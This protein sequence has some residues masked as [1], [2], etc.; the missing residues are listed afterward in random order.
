MGMRDQWVGG[1]EEGGNII[2]Q[3]V[4]NITKLTKSDGLLLIVMERW[5][6]VKGGGGGGRGMEVQG[7]KFSN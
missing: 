3:A 2:M 5:G 7:R 6:D 4:S 1:G